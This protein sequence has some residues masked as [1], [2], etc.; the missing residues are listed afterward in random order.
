L[1]Y[2]LLGL[3]Q[4]IR[5]RH[6]RIYFTARRDALRY[7]PRF[8][9]DRRRIKSK[10]RVADAYLFRIMTLREPISILFYR[11]LRAFAGRLRSLTGREN[12]VRISNRIEN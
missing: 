11:P 10:R 2:E 9:Q 7:L 8:F 4:A 5:F 12:A 6:M 1:S 3:L